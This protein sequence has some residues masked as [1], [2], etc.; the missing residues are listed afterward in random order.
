MGAHTNLV[1]V[2]KE[3][4]EVEGRDSVL[5]EAMEPRDTKGGNDPGD[6]SHDDNAHNDRHAAAI[7]S[8]K[9]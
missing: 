9:K 3:A 7:H 8:G 2:S 5:L 6:Q 4:R 1:E